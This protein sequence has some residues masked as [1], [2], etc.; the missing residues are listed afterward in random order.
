[1]LYPGTLE[2]A[3]PAFTPRPCSHLLTVHP[4]TTV[5][6]PP[7]SSFTPGATSLPLSH[8]RVI[9]LYICALVHQF[10]SLSNLWPGPALGI[11]TQARQNPS[12]LGCTD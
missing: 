9:C 3:S 2:G 1:M 11:L 10:N 6:S 5:Y 8:S 12:I 7:P 4:H